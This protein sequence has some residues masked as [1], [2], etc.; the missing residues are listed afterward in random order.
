MYLVTGATGQLGRRV[1][2]RLIALNQPVRAFVRLRSNYDLLKQWGAEIFIGDIENIRDIEK[3]CAGATYVIS[4]HASKIG[5]SRIQN[6]DYRGSIDLIDQAK[7][8]GVYHLSLV[9]P[10]AVGGD[11][12]DSPLLK[13]KYEVEAYLQNSGLNHTIFRS[14]TLMSSLLPLAERFQQT[15]VYFLMGNPEHRLQLTSPDD[16]ARIMIAASQLDIAQGQTFS[17]AHPTILTR[18]EIPKQLGYFFNRQPLVVNIPMAAIDG[19]RNVLGWLSTDL[20]T[21]MGTLRTLLAYE[22]LC[23]GSE[24]ERVQSL[25]NIQLESLEVFLNRYLGIGE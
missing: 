12:H 20:Q 7:H 4:C 10:L 6:I 2:R 17:V 11:R 13:A 9:S 19:A 22:S 16:L 8:H 24:I 15:G 21:E 3:A 1:V 14:T 18:Q 23:P 25:L 5:S